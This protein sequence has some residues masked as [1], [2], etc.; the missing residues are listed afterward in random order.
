MSWLSELLVQTAE[1]E[2]PK[3]FFYWGG[4]SAL[5]A[6][7]KDNVWIERS[8]DMP[9]YLNIYVLLFAR[10]GLRKGP[11][12]DLAKRLVRRV[13]N[14]RV[15][16]GRASMEAII[17]DLREVQ[18][19][20][21]TKTIITDSCGFITASEFSA[22]IVRSE[23]ALNIL[24]DL[25][26]RKYNQGEY[27]IRLIRT[28][29]QMLKN[30]TITMLGGINEAHFENF[31]QDKDITGGFLGRTFIIHAENKNRVNSLM[32]DMEIKI[33]EAALAEHLKLVEKLKGPLIICEAGKR[34]YDYWYNEFYKPGANEDKT[35]TFERV[36]DSALK[37]AGLLSLSDGLSMEVTKQNIIDG[38]EAAEKLT[39]AVKHVTYTIHEEQSDSTIK[40]RILKMLIKREDHK[41]TR[42][43]LL[44]ELHGVVNSENL[45][46]M[47]ETLEQAN[48]VKVY[49]LGETIIYEMPIETVKKLLY[50]IGESK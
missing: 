27:A 32:F 46:Q 22:A 5:S 29:K 47:M 39:T 9:V 43:K 23:F 2:S 16:S 4:L 34:A 42:A 1:Y 10:S 41:I 25:Y 13:G 8:G 31:L 30:P 49:M 40:K 6:V 26:D 24:T 7:C 21:N 18:T 44:Q 37:V 33:D 12:I 36:G 28:G 14:T 11:P 20:K 17:E 3:Q 50:A 19:D 15:I 35:G 48:L 45:N 38:I